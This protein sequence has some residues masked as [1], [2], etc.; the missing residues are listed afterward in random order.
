MFYE[1]LCGLSEIE[2]AKYAITQPADYLYLNQGCATGDTSKMDMENFQSM[3]TAME[4][5][6]VKVTIIDCLV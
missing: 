3:C 6:G 2:K 4:V 5:L 1:L